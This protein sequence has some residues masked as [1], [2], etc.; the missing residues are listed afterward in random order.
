M[1]STTTITPLL[2]AIWARDS[3]AL[4]SA[5]ATRSSDA[6]VASAAGVSP[7]SLCYRLRFLQ[8]AD[9]LLASGASL[10][11][12]DAAGSLPPLYWALASQTTH[13]ISAIAAATAEASVA[14]ISRARALCVALS[15][16]PDFTAK[17]LWGVKIPA[18]LAVVIPSCLLPRDELFIHKQGSALEVFFT[19]SG[20]SKAGVQRGNFSLLIANDNFLIIDH[21]LKRWANV[22]EKPPAAVNDGTEATTVKDLSCARWPSIRS[23]P[24]SKS[25]LRETRMRSG[26]LASLLGAGA[27]KTRAIGPWPETRC[28]KLEDIGLKFLVRE[29]LDGGGEKATTN[30]AAEGET[31]SANIA[32]SVVS[33]AGEGARVHNR[34][35]SRM[36][37]TIANFF[38]RGAPRPS[39]N[40]GSGTTAVNLTLS[41]VGASPPQHGCS[42]A[43]VHAVSVLG[44]GAE[45]LCDRTFI[46]PPPLRQVDRSFDT[47]ICVAPWSQV[48]FSSTTLISAIDALL[49][50]RGADATA[51]FTSIQT[52]L[53]TCDGLPV[54]FSIALLPSL[55][56]KAYVKL[57]DLSAT[58]ASGES[59]FIGLP[60][61]FTDATHLWHANTFFG[62]GGGG[63]GGSV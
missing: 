54:L 47:K 44:M 48:P 9:I 27:I 25:T 37:A 7:L 15:S 23:L 53:S 41:P 14:S 12:R 16:S 36:G 59:Q 63:G 29:P 32:T 26:V 35:S 60:P 56:V 38:I 19:M 5:L 30:I 20:Y 21:T 50:F 2:L 8:G 49:G 1:S 4:T 6:F 10:T 13:T 11:I 61:G 57:D 17:L 43:R 55:G 24:G 33:A 40:N 34:A 45:D 3:I 62:D 42:L 22:T 52:F 28:F 46:A 58:T 31:T 18:I 39:I 51:A